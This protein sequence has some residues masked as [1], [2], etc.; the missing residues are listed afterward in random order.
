MLETLKSMFDPFF[1]QGD[2]YDANESVNAQTRCVSFRA[3]TIRTSHPTIFS[4][5]ETFLFLRS[6]IF[7]DLNP[8]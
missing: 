6:N 8:R 3:T 2:N 1:T 4:T 5:M 7:I